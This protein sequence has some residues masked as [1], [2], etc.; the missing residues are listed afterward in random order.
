MTIKNFITEYT[1]SFKNN[2]NLIVLSLL[3]IIALFGN[4][5]SDLYL[6][7]VIIYSLYNNNKYFTSKLYSLEFIT[8]FIF[9]IWIV[10]CSI[11]SNNVLNSISESIPWIRF[12]LYSYALM[13]LFSLNTNFINIFVNISI[14]GTLIQSFYVFYEKLQNFDKVRL[15]GTFG[16]LKAGWYLIC[17]SLISI[18]YI[19]ENKCINIRRNK[20]N[21]FYVFYIVI[22]IISVILTGEIFNNIIFFSSLILYFI[23][24]KK[25]STL[26]VYI[27]TGYI[28]TFCIIY[29]IFK[30]NYILM[31]RYIDGFAN[32]LP[33]KTTSDYHDGWIGG[34]RVAF[35]NFYHGIGPKNYFSYCKFNLEEMKIGYFNVKECLWHPHNI[36]IQIFA[37]TGVV[38][39]ILFLIPIFIILYKSICKYL[40]GSIIEIIL[41]YILFF[42]ISTYSQAFGQ[43]KNFFWWTSFAVLIYIINKN[44]KTIENED[45]IDSKERIFISHV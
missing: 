41:C 28:I 33:W 4:T 31:E 38:G 37:E 17:F 7:F 14:F 30:Y 8:L 15:H 45:D 1:N 18:L 9:W 42:P 36:F 5:I 12:P 19:T 35:D 32:R 26:N 40:D 11:L 24:N 21:Y 27:M 16:K 34:L 20:Y 29:I 10:I 2:I 43:H 23:I 22:C 3:P 25:Y 13:A 39:L 6:V 44:D